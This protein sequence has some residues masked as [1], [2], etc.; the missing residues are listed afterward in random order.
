MSFEWNNREIQRYNLGQSFTP[1]IFWHY[2]SNQ[3]FPLNTYDLAQNFEE[4][5]DENIRAKF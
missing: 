1:A 5:F 4:H 3:Y 2:V